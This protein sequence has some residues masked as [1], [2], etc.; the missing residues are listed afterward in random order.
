[1]VIRLPTAADERAFLAMTRSSRKLHRPWVR[2]ATDASAYRQY[3][4]RIDGQR[5]VG[6]LVVL[7][8]GGDIVGVVNVSE[9]IRGRLQSAFLGYMGSAA[10][11][12][13]GLMTEGLRLVVA[14]AFRQLKLHRLEANI[15][16]G[17]LASKAVAR[18]C[19]FRKEGFS[20]RY[21]K[22]GGRWRD[23]ERWALTVEAWRR[24]NGER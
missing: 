19:G 13:R 20:P 23:H 1:V 3:L 17:N 8:D 4:L 18:R 14:H 7:R 15:Q 22:I 11:A 16:P 5:F 10:H 2:P 9:I 12:G 24:R 6:F 21:L